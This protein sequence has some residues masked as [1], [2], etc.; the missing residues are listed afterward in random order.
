MGDKPLYSVSDLVY[1]MARLRDPETGCPWDLKQSYKSITPSTIEEAYEVVDAI[2]KE[3][4]PHLKEELG[5]LVFQAIFYSQLAHED[6][7]FT[8]ADV[9]HSLVEKLIRR[10]PHVFPTGTLNPEAG[11]ASL[12]EAQV[13]RQW[14]EIKQEERKGKGVDGILA[15]VPIAL[16]AL[17]RASKLQKRAAQVGFDWPDADG[18]LEKLQEEIQELRVAISQSDRAAIEEEFGDVLFTCVNLSRHLK[19]DA[20]AALRSANAKFVNRFEYMEKE[21][22]KAGL[23]IRNQSADQLEEWWNRAKEV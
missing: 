17:T 3:D 18:V 11:S 21:I 1:L 15:D 13:K 12:D 7:L 22:A 10:H 23:D 14:E 4:Y 20:E 9:V 19:L 2:E 8:F 5:D 16:P 6:G